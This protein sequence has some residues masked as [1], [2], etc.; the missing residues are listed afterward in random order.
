[1]CIIHAGWYFLQAIII[2][3]DDRSGEIL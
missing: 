3:C 2:F 1:V